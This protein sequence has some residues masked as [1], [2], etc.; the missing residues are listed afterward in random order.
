MF[1]EF[2]TTFYSCRFNYSS[3]VH[4]YR[5]LLEAHQLEMGPR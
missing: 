5:T 4:S 2:V 1:D 3:T